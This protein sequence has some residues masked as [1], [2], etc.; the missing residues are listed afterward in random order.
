MKKFIS[1][2]FFLILIGFSGVAF[3]STVDCPTCDNNPN[4][5]RWCHP[6]APVEGLDR[7][8]YCE[9]WP[10][11]YGQEEDCDFTTFNDCEVE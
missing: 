8:G 2:T 3:G 6:S 11:M 5:D 7:S 1:T 9:S 10:V 4:G